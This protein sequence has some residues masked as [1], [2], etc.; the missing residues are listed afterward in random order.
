MGVEVPP[1]LTLILA[2]QAFTLDQELSLRKDI[3]VGV[4]KLQ[5]TSSWET[6]SEGAAEGQASKHIKRQFIAFMTL[7][8]DLCEGSGGRLLASL[9]Q[10]GGN[11]AKQRAKRDL[12]QAIGK[13]P[14][15]DWR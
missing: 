3:K 5:A 11:G 12:A 13:V 14:E 8:S 10:A 7:A 4:D 9:T 15:K 1:R 6:F 2:Q